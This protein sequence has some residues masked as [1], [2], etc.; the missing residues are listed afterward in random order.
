MRLRECFICVEVLNRISFT[1]SFEAFPHS[2]LNENMGMYFSNW[3]SD[4][5]EGCIG[6]RKIQ[7]GTSKYRGV[8]GQRTHPSD[9]LEHLRRLQFGRCRLDAEFFRLR[10]AFLS[11]LII[12]FFVSPMKSLHCGIRLPTQTIFL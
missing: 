6:L 3:T 9:S 2:H 4:T 7:E 11:A 5:G 8:W 1:K 12:A 10:A